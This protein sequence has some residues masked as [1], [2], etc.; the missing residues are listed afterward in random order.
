MYCNVV[1]WCEIR[2]FSCSSIP[3]P[4]PSSRQYQYLCAF[5]LNRWLIW[6]TL[7]R[8]PRIVGDQ[9]AAELSYTGRTFTGREAE[10]MGLVLQCFDTEADMMK[11]VNAVAAQIASKSPIT[12]RYEYY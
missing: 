11:H 5:I 7:Q 9:R 8:L 12:T 4:Y 3:V 1:L 2:D 10:Q 6:G